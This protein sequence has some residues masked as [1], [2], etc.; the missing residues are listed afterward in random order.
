MV[1]G[2]DRDAAGS[3]GAK[4]LYAI[5]KTEEHFEKKKQKKT[6]S[7]MGYSLNSG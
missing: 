6:G 4:I 7:T 2:I 5:E 1:S 3:R